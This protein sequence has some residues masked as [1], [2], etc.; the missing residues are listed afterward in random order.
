MQF[1]KF[2]NFSDDLVECVNVTFSS[3]PRDITT[4]PEPMVICPENATDGNSLQIPYSTYHEGTV[5]LLV[6]TNDSYALW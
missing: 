3:D 1:I 2:H 5:I 4:L 6:D